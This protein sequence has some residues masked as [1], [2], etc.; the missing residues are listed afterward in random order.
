MDNMTNIEKL[1]AL[2]PAHPVRRIAL[3]ELEAIKN[4]KMR[5]CTWR[6]IWEC[7]DWNFPTQESFVG[8]ASRMIRREYGRY[9]T[10][11]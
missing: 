2:Q 5:G 8:V 11:Y 10:R 4:A 9:E 6:E 7:G 3:D 1:D